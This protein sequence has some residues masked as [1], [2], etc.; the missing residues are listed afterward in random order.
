VPKI[1]LTLEARAE[2]INKA[3]EGVGQRINEANRAHPLKPIDAAA[4][5]REGARAVEKVQK[6]QDKITQVSEKAGK[7]EDEIQA[8]RRSETEKAEDKELARRKRRDENREPPSD[9]PRD[10]RVRH[11]IRRRYTYA[12]EAADIGRSFIG[13]IGG[14]V[15]HVAGYAQRGAVAGA[16]EGGGMLG[17]AA[18]LL[19]G[20]LIGAAVLGAL[21]IGQSA[22]EGYDMASERAH[23]LD[24][25]KRQMGDVGVS[26]DRLK[27]ASEAAASGLAINAKDFAAV[28]AT[29]NAASG[30][31]VEASALGLAAAANTTTGF[32]R[33]YGM[34]PN[35]TASLFGG[36][37]NVDPKRSYMEFAGILAQ[38]IE[39]TG[40]SGSAA[41]V[42]QAVL[43]FA[44][45]ASRL[46]L[47]QANI[48][49]YAG[50]YAGLTTMGMPGLTSEA[51][52]G[53]LAQA[54]AAA[55]NMG[56][57]GEAGQAFTLAAFQRS[58]RRLNPLEAMAEASGG[59]FA[60]RSSTFAPDTVD[61]VTGK[62]VI[63]SAMGHLLGKDAA[64]RA[65]G[66]GADKTNFEMIAEQAQR[67]AGGKGPEAKEL[68]AEM[69][70]RYYGLQS[71]Q[72][73]AALM[74][75]QSTM[76]PG[77]MKG[78]DS[79]LKRAGVDVKDFNATN[80]QTVGKIAGSTTSAQLDDVYADL[81][82]RTG[83]AALSKTDTDNIEAAKGKGFTQYQD[84]LVK[85][86][87]SK[88]YAQ[89]SYTVQQ[90]MSAKLDDIKLW[91]GEKMLGAVTTMDENMIALLGGHKG[92]QEG[93][94]AD[95]D[96]Q[97]KQSAAAVKKEQDA[98][99]DSVFDPK[100]TPGYF[101]DST[102]EQRATVDKQTALANYNLERIREKSEDAKDAILHPH[103]P[104]AP[105]TVDL[106]INFKN[107]ANGLPLG[108]AP[109]RVS[110]PAAGGSAA[111]RAK[112]K[113][114]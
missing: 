3:I 64:A 42:T 69:L 109:A 40:K 114:P 6:H 103:G 36:A 14:G 78:L 30:R 22:N 7:R 16:S 57:A 101:R 8:R 26:F 28:E 34:D 18:G 81:Q 84:A 72:Q 113:S 65:G 79:V 102:P 48:S 19:K 83:T 13:G 61:P 76:K 62:N 58:G 29:L 77:D 10:D 4:I 21:K 24:T 112:S 31:G 105:V 108:T 15:G 53:I 59:L 96:W 5:D 17:G 85:A 66:P 70:Q 33:A 88:D 55:S 56:A 54:N 1:E 45:T 111:N 71:I 107:L 23:T 110:V 20:T 68:Q 9:N 50:A 89:D 90:E 98:G 87:A 25:L 11:S 73:A 37:K 43:S 52:A 35:Q 47:S 91:A 93:R 86:T 92:L 51:S 41:E 44:A 97:A 63:N 27:I 82:T 32:A 75:L 100:K 104:P 2:G 49:G 12:P 46:S 80:I 74:N 106:L 38:T 94:L 99:Y 95:V 67:V 39:R 60:S